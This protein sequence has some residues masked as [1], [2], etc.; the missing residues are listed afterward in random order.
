[1]NVLDKAGETPLS[2]A[3]YN[4]NVPVVQALVEHKGKQ[5]SNI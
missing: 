1:V 4:N 3:V 5:Y 2:I